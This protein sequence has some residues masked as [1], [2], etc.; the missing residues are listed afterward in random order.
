MGVIIAKWK[1]SGKHEA[2]TSVTGFCDHHPGFN[3]KEIWPIFRKGRIFE[4]EE[5]E[6]RKVIVFQ[7]L[8]KQK[9][10]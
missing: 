9:K 4:T 1:K 2:Y 10:H 7:R 5:L 6:L 8:P 3:A